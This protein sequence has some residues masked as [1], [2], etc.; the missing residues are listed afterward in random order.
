MITVT[1]SQPRERRSTNEFAVLSRQSRAASGEKKKTGA[2]GGSR[3]RAGRSGGHG[4]PGVA[5]GRAHDWRATRKE[6]QW[7]TSGHCVSAACSPLGG[8]NCSARCGCKANARGLGGGVHDARPSRVLCVLHRRQRCCRGRF[9]V[10]SLQ[11]TQLWLSA[12]VRNAAKIC[13]RSRTRAPR[14]KGTGVDRMCTSPPPVASRDPCMCPCCAAL[15]LLLGAPM[16]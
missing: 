2:N 10:C 16:T 3:S 12:M 13:R 5:P 15:Q 9:L 6:S 7:P 11:A 1:T 14:W 4:T 8:V